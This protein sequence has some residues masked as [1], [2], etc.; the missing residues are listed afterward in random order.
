LKDPESSANT[1][2]AIETAIGSGSI[3][4]LQNGTQTGWIDGGVSRAEEVLNGIQTVLADCELAFREIDTIATSLGPG[5]FTGIRI[6]V[7]TGLGLKRSLSA[8]LVGVNALEAM[9]VLFPNERRVVVLPLGRGNYALQEFDITSIQGSRPSVVNENGLI[10]IACTRSKVRFIF[11]KDLDVAVKR[12]PMENFSVNT[13]P[14]A[15]LIGRRA[16]AG[17]GTEDGRPLYLRNPEIAQ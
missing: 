2:L 3:S 5:S 14:L 8:K 17:K 1:I 4:I 15:T 13:E 9:S 10:Q 7:A 16:F 6:G 12:M 11:H